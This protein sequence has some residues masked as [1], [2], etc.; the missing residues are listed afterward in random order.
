[1]LCAQKPI[2]QMD[3]YAGWR[4]CICE[5]FLL[6]RISKFKRKREKTRFYLLLLSI[7]NVRD[8]RAVECKS[9][10]VLL[11]PGSAEIGQEDAGTYKS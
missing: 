4:L 10:T 2:H 3:E 5:L 6:G 11:P 1:M 9:G 7:H 8:Q